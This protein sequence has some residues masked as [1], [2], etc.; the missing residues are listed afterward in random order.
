M[1]NLLPS[2]TEQYIQPW[3]MIQS[4]KKMCIY[5]SV[6]KHVNIYMCAGIR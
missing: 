3:G 5:V 2:V 1:T 4:M 6:N